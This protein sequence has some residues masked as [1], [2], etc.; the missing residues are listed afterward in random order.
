M[1]SKYATSP[2]IALTAQVPAERAEE[3]AKLALGLGIPHHRLIV[4]ALTAGLPIAVAKAA[5]AAQ[6]PTAVKE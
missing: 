2:R 5:S 4:M 6:Q 1:K 3:I